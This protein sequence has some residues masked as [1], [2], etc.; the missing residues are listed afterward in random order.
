M[1]ETNRIEAR[2]AKREGSSSS[3]DATLSRVKFKDEV[4]EE[5]PERVA[6]K[7]RRATERAVRQ[8]QGDELAAERKHVKKLSAIMSVAVALAIIAIGFAAYV[9]FTTAAD[10]NTMS[11][12]SREVLVASKQIS[13]GQT[14][15]SADVTFEQVPSRY[16]NDGALTNMEDV[17]GKTVVSTIYAKEQFTSS[18]LFGSGNTSSLATAL[19][20]G[21]FG[22][23]IPTTVASGLSG[24][25]NQDDAVDVYVTYVGTAG[26]TRIEKVLERV[27]VVALDANLDDATKSYSSITVQVDSADLVAKFFDASSKGEVSV[28]LYATGEGRGE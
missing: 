4:E 19:D 20:N 28:S 6:R 27:R 26:T 14:V 15:T 25:I 21:T 9:Q 8:R 24:L 23:T 18:G 22:L 3:D 5:A 1:A 13:A 7:E 2:R 16:I 12:N 17:V 10:L 11:E